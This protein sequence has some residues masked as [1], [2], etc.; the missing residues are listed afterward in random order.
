MEQQT[1]Y[2]DEIIA[3]AREA[4]ARPNNGHGRPRGA[5]NRRNREL[6]ALAKEYS[7]PVLQRV[8]A[9]AL[10]GDMLA[11]KII[12]DRVWPRP[13]SAPLSIELPPARSPADVRAAMYDLLHRTAAGEIGAEEAGALVG[14]CK[15]ILIAE[16]IETTEQAAAPS[17]LDP[18]AILTDR[19]ARLI[20]ARRPADPEPAESAASR[21][22][23]APP[24]TPFATPM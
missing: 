24:L 5:R 3:P 19:L 8:Y 6:H 15:D 22:R 1:L 12:L 9:A 20:E 17:N 4:A 10:A 16:R 11:A 21:G 13:R 23:R 18:R 7:L 2:P 14:M